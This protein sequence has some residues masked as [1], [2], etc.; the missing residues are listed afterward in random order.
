M[1]DERGMSM[2]VMVT[3]W[4]MALVVIAG[5]AVDGGQRVHAARR[6]EGAASGAARAATD[7]AATS[8][9][10]GR[11]DPGV[12][13]LA[14][15]AHLTASGVAGSVELDRGV[16]RVRTRV[17]APTIFLSIVGVREVSAGAYAESVLLRA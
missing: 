15:R 3:L 12:A 17:G 2:S 1:R 13:V 7:A 9:L 4:V 16:V 10:G 11:T 8:R 14:A 6:A 5:L